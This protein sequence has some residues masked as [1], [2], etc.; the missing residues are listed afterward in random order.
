MAIEQEIV[1]WGKTRLWWQQEVLGRLAA[2]KPVDQTYLSSLVDD[3]TSNVSRTVTPLSVG[4]LPAGQAQGKPVA[5]EAIR[6]LQGVN[7]LLPGQALTFAPSGLTVI[8]GHNASGKSGY[9]RLIKLLAGARHNEMILPDVFAQGGSSSQSASVSFSHDG[10]SEFIAWPGAAS[11]LQAIHFYDEACGNAYLGGDSEL[12]Y[13]P[14]ALV[15]LD[16]LIVACDAL[17]E[18]LDQ[19]LRKNSEAKGAL[20]QPPE[21]TPAQTF[22]EQLSAT[23]SQP[24]IDEAVMVPDNAADQLASLLQE[25]GRLRASDPQKERLRLESLATHVQSL[26]KHVKSIDLVLNDTAV[27]KAFDEQSKARNL[28]AAAAIASSTTFDIEPIPGVGAQTWRALWEAAK[29]YSITEAYCD[30]EF[31]ATH[32]D[33]RCVLCQQ[34]LSSEASNRLQRFDAFMKDTTEQDAQRAETLLQQ[35]IASRRALNISPSSATTSLVEMRGLDEKM[36]E[37]VSEWLR[38]AEERRKGLVEKLVASQDDTAVPPLGAVPSQRLAE[39]GS[40]LQTHAASIDAT[41]FKTQLGDVT[42]R[43]KNLQGRLALEQNRSKLT[44]EIRR[45]AERSGLEKAKQAT[46]TAA[47]TRRS[48]DLTRSHVTT[49]VRDRFTRESEQ[50]RLER[51]T[52]NDAGGKKGKLRHRPALLGATGGESVEKVF[53]EGEQTALGLAGYFTEAY[54]DSSKSGMVLDDPV[55]SLD[56]VRRAVVANRLA[57]FGKERQVVVFTHDA[58]FVGDL[59]KAADEESIAFTERCIQRRGDGTPGMCT[60]EHP[61]KVKDVGARL[62]QMEQNLAEIKRERPAWTQEQYEDA[63]AAWGGKLSELW[64]R[65]LSLE[66]DVVVDRATLEVRPKMFKVLAKITEHDNKEFQQSYGRSSLWARRH[67]KNPA[68]NYVAPEPDDMES[69]LR[70]VKAWTARVKTYKK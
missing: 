65:V 34:Q 8:Y 21:G 12:T 57:K 39:I 70:L 49:I 25:E 36:T 2:G 32:A 23:T 38:T 42:A 27:E 52:L 19:R 51:I 30:H 1:D 3:L 69:E 14:S 29:T 9:A 40:T 31:P 62:T 22:V 37:A 16:D 45:L 60:D 20:P 50:L 5:L 59:R 13:R 47:I 48:A 61:W 7:A 64:E 4:D 67:D 53:S 58:T 46:D 66:V 41:V 24:Q 26:S 17:R 18:I 11:T 68:V 44:V 63:C 10:A 6:D 56:H 28:R 15:L 33:A 54:F 55:T 35:L 43:R